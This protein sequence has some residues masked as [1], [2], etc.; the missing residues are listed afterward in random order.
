[1]KGKGDDQMKVAIGIE[2][3]AK[4]EISDD[5]IQVNYEHFRNN[6]KAVEN[7]QEALQEMML[8]KVSHLMERINS[9]VINLE[10]L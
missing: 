6:L 3:E 8:G 5:L 4:I 7:D 2:D 1:M 10:I 9:T